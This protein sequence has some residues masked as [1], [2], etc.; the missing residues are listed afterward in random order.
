MSTRIVREMAFASASHIFT[1]AQLVSCIFIVSLV[2]ACYYAQLFL[3][4]LFF[5]I[6]PGFP[7]DAGLPEAVACLDSLTDDTVSVE[8]TDCATVKL[9]VETGNTAVDAVRNTLP[10]NA[11]VEVPNLSAAYRALIDGK[12]SAVAGGRAEVAQPSAALNGYSEDSY[13]VGANLLVRDPLAMVARDN[14]RRWCDIIFWTQQALVSAEE[15]GVT[16]STADDLSLTSAFGEEFD[17]IFVEMIR[18]VGNYGEVYARNVEPIIP[19]AGMDTINEGE[20]GRLYSLPFG[21]LSVQGDNPLDIPESTISK[22]HRRGHLR[23]GITRR[24]SFA[25]FSPENLEFEGYDV[26][27]CKA[28]SAAIFDGPTDNVVYVDLPASSR[29]EYIN[30]GI[31]DVLSRITTHTLDRD[32][33]EPTTGQGFSF[34]VPNF[35]DGLRFGG[36]PPYGQCADNLDTSSEGCEDLRIC[37]NAGTTTE[38]GVRSLF[39]DDFIWVMPGGEL[40]L[41]GLVTGDCNVVAGGSHDVAIRSVESVGYTGP[42]EIGVNTFSKDPLAI[43]TPEDDPSFSDFCFW[44]LQA[45]I[46]AEEKGIAMV[47]AAEEM[48]LTNLYGD[49]FTRMLQ[50]AVQAVGS[51]AELYERNIER[52]VPRAG[53]NQLN[54]NGGPQLYAIPGVFSK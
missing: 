23:C 33:K 47:S 17:N 29:F 20:T 49:L 53:L 34:T 51:T 42:Y 45:T 1:T 26:D 9:C 39:A 14:D 18:A 41:M 25:E 31:V 15:Q 8:E 11:I 52:L 35:Y 46:F 44:V 7:L 37:V 30:D 3:T 54:D 38:Q 32:V 10:E 19:R 12:C 16:Q 27:Y 2:S 22:I 24:A 4:T 6:L 43:M 21:D 13:A 40:S 48:P 5:L 36:I 28:I 50:N